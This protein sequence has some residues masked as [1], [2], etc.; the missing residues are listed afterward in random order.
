MISN[1]VA[2]SF[3]FLFLALM[4]LIGFSL[5]L[6]VMFNHLP[7]N[8]NVPEYREQANEFFGTLPNS[9]LTL[10]YAL[11]ANFPSE[12]LSLFPDGTLNDCCVS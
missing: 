5:G 6:H 4:I 11:F 3:Y 8:S 10:F 9:M 12:V 7:E 1:I 2:E